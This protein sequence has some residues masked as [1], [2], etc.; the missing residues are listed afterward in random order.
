M[1]WRGLT[2]NWGLS[3][4]IVAFSLLLLL[5]IQTAVFSVIRVSIDQSARQQITQELQV[6]ERVWRRLLDQNALKLAQGATLLAADFGFRSAVSTGDVDTIRSALDN[7]GARIGAT[8]TAL[9]DNS[10]NLTAIGQGQSSLA[11]APDVK[12]AEFKQIYQRLAR[13]PQSGQI[14]MIDQV[15]HQFVM[16]QVRA[17]TPIGWVLMGF[18]IGQSLLDEMRTLSEMHVALISVRS[19]ADSNLL[20]STLPANAARILK[21]SRGPVAEL[22]VGSDTLVALDVKLDAG[23]H[24]LHT[25]LLRS[26]DEVVAPFRR[27]QFALAWITA[28]GVVLFGIGSVFLARRV[29]TPLRSLVSA[30]E[31]LGKGDYTTPMEHMSRKDE[32]GGLATAFDQMRVSIGTQQSE[33]R[34]LAYWDQLTGLPNRARFR[35]AAREA[36][37]RAGKTSDK[38]SARLAIVVLDLDRF[39]HV[40]DALGY[41][42]GDSVLQAV[43]KR[44]ALHEMGPN[45]LLARLGGNEFA[46]LLNHTDSA[47]AYQFAQRVASSFEEPLTFAD[48]SIDLSAGIGIACWPEHAADADTLLGLAEVAMYA[49]KAKATGVQIYQPSLDSSSTQSLSLLTELRHAVEHNELRLYLQPK[50][51]LNLSAA[52]SVEALVR[53]QHPT[54]GLVPPVEFIPFA[55]QTGFVRQLTLWIFNEAARVWPELQKVDQACQI[56]VNLSARDLMDPA[57]PGNLQAILKTHNVPASGFCLEIT[58]SAIM[59][60]PQRAEATLNR[61]NECGFKLS[62]DDFGTGYSS[63]A[64][65]KRLPVDQLK[66]DKSFVMAMEKVKG[67]AVI[68]RSTIDL[69]HNLSLTVVAEGVENAVVYNLLKK[70]GCDQAQGYLISKPMPA[71]EYVAW[72]ERWNHQLDTNRRESGLS[73]PI[74]LY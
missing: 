33:I 10:L 69:A 28:L 42:F 7:H 43:A 18:P 31:K 72:R 47:T 53:W 58:E 5:L 9:I 11:R 8:V 39:K 56:A 2:H 23:P 68:V 32:I 51:E 41:T 46:L 64:Y 67:D 20:M 49:A 54:R 44:L 21:E 27:A 50:I 25:L 37:E 55:E 45:D 36:I 6:G 38:A 66:I 16:V 13:S 60:D 19:N 24:D 12:Q 30:T 70:L 48:Q 63:L 59:D 52:T 29:T 73:I 14:A 26:F 3:A 4:R 17:P 62:I 65:L 61:L 1:I 74:P 35:E 15:P 40:N 22:L 57:L 71:S 34:R